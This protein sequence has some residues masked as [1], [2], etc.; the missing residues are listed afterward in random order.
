MSQNQPYPGTGLSSSRHAPSPLRNEI[1]STFPAA[2]P[3]R[4][5]A[6]TIAPK[7]QIEYN[8]DAQLAIKQNLQLKDAVSGYLEE[9]N[10]FVSTMAEAT[11]KLL[12]LIRESANSGGPTD[13]TAVEA[14]DKLWQELKRLFGK[15]QQ[16]KDIMP[17]FL[18]QQKENMSLYHNSMMNENMHDV[19]EELNMQYK[20]VNIQHSLILEH[21]ASFKRYKDQTEE[22]LQ[23]LTELTERASRLNLEKGLFR[24]EIEKY[25]KQIEEI[26]SGGEK[27]SKETAE[28]S[29][30]LN[31]IR[32]A[33]SALEKDCDEARKAI[34]ELKQ[35]TEKGNQELRNVHSKE[36]AE[37]NTQLK[38]ALFKH[39]TLKTHSATLEKKSADF[40]KEAK[41][42]EEELNMAKD[43]FN[44][45][46][47]EFSKLFR[48]LT[49]KTTYVSSLQN[50]VKRLDKEVQEAKKNAAQAPWEDLQ[51]QVADLSAEKSKLESELEKFKEQTPGIE[52]K[53]SKSIAETEALKRSNKKLQRDNDEL[54]TEANDLA[55]K[56]SVL[57]ATQK[58]GT[59]D[60]SALQEENKKLRS[61]I[62]KLQADQGQGTT[63]PGLEDLEGL[64]L[65]LR[66]FE[67]QHTKLT[68]DVAAWKGLAH[69]S[70]EEFKKLAAEYEE[71][72]GFKDECIKKDAQIEKLTAELKSNK[73]SNDMAGMDN[74]DAEYWK[75][76]YEGV[77][78]QY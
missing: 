13:K 34:A 25:Q 45:Q 11:H 17:N 59:T 49:E 66:T 44:N 4:G 2:V 26:K 6:L 35:R 43:K 58:N 68:E 74:K 48:Q 36:L 70:Y 67:A 19:Q 54:E 5:Q 57:K 56:I 31:A 18:E 30:E 75:A 62:E 16:V 46:S 21:Q 61:D 63:P 22:K 53:L 28:L 47:L 3:T 27:H 73:L 15:V 42:K 40:E 8:P 50:E 72:K 1:F 60:T 76:K 33:K 14:M 7:E 55:A 10:G 38:N 78:S 24:A 51:K 9:Y 39:D 52:E 65:K 29:K 12:T 69:R 23:Q 20:K 77:L 64:G 32:E 41:Q 37:A 71:V